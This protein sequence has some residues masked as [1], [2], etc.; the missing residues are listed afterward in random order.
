MMTMMMMMMMAV[1]LMMMMMTKSA[2]KL[3]LLCFRHELERNKPLVDK[4]LS[5][6]RFVK[7]EILLIK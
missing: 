3:Y 5:D 4:L 2:A 1:M 6:I 7:H